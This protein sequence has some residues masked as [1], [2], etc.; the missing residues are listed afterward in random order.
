MSNNKSGIRGVSFDKN[1]NK[2]VAY[3]RF[4][5]QQVLRRTFDAKQEAVQERQRFE[6]KYLAYV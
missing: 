2:W 6:K 1:K 3:M 4:N 5:H